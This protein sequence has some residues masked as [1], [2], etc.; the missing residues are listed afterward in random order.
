M[1]WWIALDCLL[2]GSGIW[3]VMASAGRREGWSGRNR[4]GFGA[5]LGLISALGVAGSFRSVEYA[6]R[7]TVNPQSAAVAEQPAVVV[8]R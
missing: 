8:G 4:H 7:L 5:A 6:A 1:S 3:F 2:I